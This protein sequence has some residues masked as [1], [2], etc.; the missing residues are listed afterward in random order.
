MHGNSFSITTPK[1]RRISWIRFYVPLVGLCTLITCSGTK[2][3]QLALS[4]RLTR[5]PVLF[6]LRRVL[7]QQKARRKHIGKPRPC[8]KR[9]SLTPVSGHASVMNLL[10]KQE[11]K[12]RLGEGGVRPR[13][14]ANRHEHE[15][16]MS[17]TLRCL[18]SSTLTGGRLRDGS[19][20]YPSGLRSKY[21]NGVGA[22]RVSDNGKSALDGAQHVTLAAT[23]KIVR[24]P[25]KRQQKKMMI[26]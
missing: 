22:K 14:D 1:W 4:A 6:R 10:R 7:L 11:Q 3:R 12:L 26:S 8:R 13:Q 15:A 25:W 24:T 5:D 17:P 21:D 16:V 19:L 23:Q 20:T 18:T 2:A 9:C